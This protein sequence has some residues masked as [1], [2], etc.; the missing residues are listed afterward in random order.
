M[1]GH[2]YELSSTDYFVNNEVDFHKAFPK[3]FSHTTVFNAI[4]PHPHASF[5]QPRG[6]DNFKKLFYDFFFFWVFDIGGC[7]VGVKKNKKLRVV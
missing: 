6:L 4:P 2:S 7:L 5:D 3:P 1:V